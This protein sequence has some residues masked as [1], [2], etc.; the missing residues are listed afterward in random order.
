[1][2]GPNHAVLVAFLLLPVL[3][4]YYS[5]MA[6]LIHCLTLIHCALTVLHTSHAFVVCRTT[7]LRYSSSVWS[8]PSSE[9]PL[10]FTNCS[11]TLRTLAQLQR[12][13]QWLYQVVCFHFIHTCSVHTHQV[14]CGL[15][16]AHLIQSY[17]RSE[18][19]DH[20]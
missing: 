13:E 4:P 12:H 10:L 19:G 16:L 14:S 1:M 2:V 17:A 6:S 9:W 11:K 8:S 7:L 3:V 15:A 18:I 20:W 5:T